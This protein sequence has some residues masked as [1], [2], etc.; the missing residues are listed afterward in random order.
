M[1]IMNRITAVEESDERDSSYGP[2]TDRD[3]VSSKAQ[4]G[5]SLSVDL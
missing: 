3:H 5:P 1:Q 4:S 2:N